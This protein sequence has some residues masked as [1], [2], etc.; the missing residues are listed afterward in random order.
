MLKQT[1]LIH[2]SFAFCLISV[3]ETFF[4][5]NN[6]SVKCNLCEVHAVCCFFPGTTTCFTI[7]CW[8]LQ[9]RTGRSSSCSPLKTTS[10]SSRYSTVQLSHHILLFTLLSIWVKRQQILTFNLIQYHPPLFNLLSPLNHFQTL[11]MNCNLLCLQS[12]LYGSTFIHC[13]D[14]IFTKTVKLLNKLLSTLPAY[15][16]CVSC[17]LM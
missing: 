7:C 11:L 1:K 3:K 15:C 10:T 2:W 12:D 5:W 16:A 8:E 4:F 14:S 6:N 13:V 17:M 9:R